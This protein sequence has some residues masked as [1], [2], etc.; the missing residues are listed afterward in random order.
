MEKNSITSFTLCPSPFFWERGFDLFL[1]SYKNKSRVCA[2]SCSS[3]SPWRADGKLWR[4]WPYGTI[5]RHHQTLFWDRPLTPRT[6]RLLESSVCVCVCVSLSLLS[7]TP[8]HLLYWSVC[9]S[10]A[11]ARGSTLT[12][13]PSAIS[14]SSYNGNICVC[15]KD[16]YTVNKYFQDLLS[17][18]IFFCQINFIII[19]L[20]KI[21]YYFE[22]LMI[23]F[24]FI[25]LTHFFQFNQLK[26]W[27]QPRLLTFLS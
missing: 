4:T 20:V 16:W 10:G 15:W 22:F 24:I 25:V 19:Y 12:I 17:Q 14:W 8:F 5:K 9:R 27:R 3:R 13:A 23:K 2:D 21:T 26:I 18:H 7:S 11:L 6:E 1:F